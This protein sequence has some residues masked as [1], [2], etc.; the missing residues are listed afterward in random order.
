MSRINTVFSRMYPKTLHLF[1]NVGFLCPFVV[2]VHLYMHFIN[3]CL[4]VYDKHAN[5]LKLI[6]TTLRTRTVFYLPLS[7]DEHIQLISVNIEYLLRTHTKWLAVHPRTMPAS[8]LEYMNLYS[9][10]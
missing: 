5:F 10:V 8:I 4:W 3:Y 1:I 6:M 2:Q 9:N 7:S